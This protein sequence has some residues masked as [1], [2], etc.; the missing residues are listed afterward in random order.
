MIKNFFIIGAA[1]YIAKRHVHS[2]CSIPN[3]KIIAAYDPC[4][5]VGYLDSYSYDIEYFCEISDFKS[6]IGKHKK[7]NNYLV[8]CSPNHT[9]FAY[10]KYGLSINFKIICE[11]PLCFYTNHISYFKKLSLDKKNDINVIL[12]LRNSSLVK[13][14]KKYINSIPQNDDKLSLVT[15]NYY[16]PRGKW[17][18]NTWKGDKKKSGGILFNIGIHLFDIL[19][20]LFGKPLN[21]KINSINMQKAKGYVIFKNFKVNWNLSLNSKDLKKKK[22][23]N[24]VRELIIN[25]KT[26]E[27]SEQFQ[28]LHLSSY[29][30]I[31]KSKRSNL[32]GS[33]LSLDLVN[34]MLN[35]NVY[36]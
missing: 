20:Y 12:Q 9:H 30:K 27:F 6:F 7:K 21:Y 18:Y 5:N 19:I 17:Y 35:K 28:N 23:I 14:I 2:I 4:S 31:L 34:K 24:S 13:K 22:S 1:G 16:T 33:L 11:K 8:V 15:L 26:F 29:K 25:K 36:T 10:I 3:T 32:E